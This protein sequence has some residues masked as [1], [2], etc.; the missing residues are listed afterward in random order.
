VKKR[1]TFRPE[2][3]FVPFPRSLLASLAWQ[4]LSINPRRFIDFLMLEYL[5]HGGATNGNLLGPR[6]QLIEFG[7]GSHFISGAIDEVK[8]HGLVDVI[9]GTGRAPNRYALTW[10]PL[11]GETEPGDRWRLYEEGP[12][13][14]LSSRS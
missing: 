13:R 1:A 5:N 6:K 2:R 10:L 14:C 8:S 7:I 3:P 11:A 9:R 4:T 12:Q